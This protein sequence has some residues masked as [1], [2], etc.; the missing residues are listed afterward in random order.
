MGNIKHLFPQV[1]PIPWGLTK[2]LLGATGLALCVLVAMN[3][4]IAIQGPSEMNQQAI[5]FIFCFLIWFTITYLIAKRPFWKWMAEFRV[6]NSF[7][8]YVGY[9]LVDGKLEHNTPSK[10]RKKM[11]T[12]LTNAKHDCF[13][14]M[15]VRKGF[16][17]DQLII[18]SNSSWG[19]YI[20][21]K[22][23]TGPNDSKP[24][25]TI[26]HKDF[27]FQQGEFAITLPIERILKYAPELEYGVKS[28]LHHTIAERDRIIDVLLY[29]CELASK[30]LKETRRFGKGS[31]PRP[32][33]G[34]IAMSV[35]GFGKGTNSESSTEAKEI[36]EML[37]ENLGKAN[38]IINNF[39]VPFK[40]AI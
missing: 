40:S 37:E 17:L 23:V 13:V 19:S 20:N 7:S 36:R 3:L 31:N 4:R 32:S 27:A 21:L 29:T 33:K 34:A 1:A 30:Q 16:H 14:I 2:L 28:F 6:K 26:N 15:A 10:D 5:I 12:E 24:V 11:I 39:C 25:L 8:Y 18:P 38:K 35:A 22:D 9:Y